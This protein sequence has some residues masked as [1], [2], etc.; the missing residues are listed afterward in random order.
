VRKIKLGSSGSTQS[1][2]V[3]CAGEIAVGDR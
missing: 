2:D 3:P 1:I